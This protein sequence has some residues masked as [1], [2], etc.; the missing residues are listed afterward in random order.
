MLNIHFQIQYVCV[1]ERERERERKREREQALALSN[2]EE[3]IFFKIQ[4]NQSIIFIHSNDTFVF[5]KV[6]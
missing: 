2:P 1:C 6:L 3:L 4:P 5:S